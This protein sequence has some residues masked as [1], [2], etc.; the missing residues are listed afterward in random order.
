MMIMRPP[1]QGHGRG[2]MRG[3]VGRW[4][5]GLWAVRADRH[6]EQLARPCD[7]G[8]AVAIGKQAVVADAMEAVGSTCIRKRRMNSC[9]AS[10]M[11]F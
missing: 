4:G 6:G 9:G 7:I 10:V 1:Q 5:L 3:F 2:S 11:V 8:G